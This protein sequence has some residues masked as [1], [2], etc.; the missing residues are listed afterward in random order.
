VQRVDGGLDEEDPE[1]GV[2]AEESVDEVLVATPDLV[3]GLEG[4]HDDVGHRTL[5]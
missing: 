5:R 1:L 2:R 4:Q 3:P